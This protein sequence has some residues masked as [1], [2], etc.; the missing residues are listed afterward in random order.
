LRHF[1]IGSFH[2][3]DEFICLLHAKAHHRQ[4][5]VG[6]RADEQLR[7]P[8]EGAAGSAAYLILKTRSPGVLASSSTNDGVKR[9]SIRPRCQLV[10]LSERDGAFT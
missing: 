8:V 6:L 7:L 1:G 3:D 2:I 10:D 5:S 4:R 9:I